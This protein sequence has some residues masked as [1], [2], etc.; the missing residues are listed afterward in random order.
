MGSEPPPPPAAL[1]TGASRG[2]GRGIAEALA[3]DGFDVAIHYATN[4][5]AAEET[6]AACRR[7]APRP[8][9]RF[10]AVGGN[11]A[12]AGDRRRMVDETLAALGRIDTLVN[13]AGMAPR[14]RA[15]ILDATEE[16][17]DELIAV[18][19]RGPYFLSQAVARHWRERRGESRLPGGYKLIFVSSIS[20][21]MAS[22][23][24]GDYCLSKAGIA[25]AAKLWATR[26]AAEGVQVFEVRPGI[27]RTDMTAGV[28]EKYDRMIAD[29]LVPHGRWGTAED[30]GR[31]VV[32]LMGGGLPF[33]TGEVINVDGGLH[34]VR[35]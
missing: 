28:K 17:F 33:S 27:M 14:V 11:V 34:L 2:L 24:R 20:A 10:V 1:V 29:G 23:N 8:A 9:Q 15:D 22:V 12:D 19:L 30:V 32:A 13:N 4:R 18:N 3:G 6:R 5:A 26:L 7:R 31:T 16:S 25:M 35:L 21:V